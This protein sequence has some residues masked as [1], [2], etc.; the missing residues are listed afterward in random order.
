MGTTPS[1][2]ALQA[3]IKLGHIPAVSYAC[4]EHKENEKHKFVRTS[5]SVGKKNLQ[6][7]DAEMTVNNKTRFP[8]SSLSKIVFTYLILQLVKQKQIALDEPLHD[9]LHYERFKVDGEYPKKAKELTARHIL[10]HTTGLPNFGASLSSPLIFDSKSKLSEGYS[11]SGEAFLYLQKAIE[12]KIGKDLETLAQEYVFAPL[13]MSRSTFMPTSEDDD[14]VV[15][16]HTELGKPTSIYVGEP[17]VN[18][19]GSLLTT[20]DDFSKLMV[21]WLENMKDPLIEQAFEPMNTDGLMTCGLGWHIYRHEDEVIAYQYG[22]NPNTRAFIAINITTQKGAVFFTNSE[23]G[24]SIANQVFCSPDLT[25]IGTM[26]RIYKQLHYTQCDEPGWQETILGKIAEIDDQFEEA[27]YYFEKAFELSP[28]D[29]TKLRRL[30]W[31]KLVHHP[32]PKQEST[33]SMNAFVG[34]YKNL[35][36]D[37]VEISIRDGGLIF[38]Q[39]DQQIKLVQVA[40]AEFLPE[41]DQS[42]KI[43]FDGDHLSIYFVHGGRNKFLS[44]QH[45]PKYS[46][47]YKD[48]VR[49]LRVSQLEMQYT[50]TTS[51]PSWR[52]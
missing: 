46:L 50:D 14:N 48:E 4:V 2:T 16:V 12:A 22:E 1:M 41:K 49:Q 47:Q 5:I 37:D 11:Y 34:N 39:F 28:E 43:G 18:A 27:K 32:S 3:I 25:P 44:K 9:I 30:E 31:F 13:K 35:Y 26:D 33:L 38:K 40:E 52:S 10:S 6:P 23:N 24:M 42:F 51:K 36:N 19:A 8:A 15:A 20:A 21:A 17:L 7:K 45:S 29:E